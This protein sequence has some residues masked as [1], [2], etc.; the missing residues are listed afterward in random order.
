MHETSETVSLRIF[1]NIPVFGSQNFH[2][3]HI[4]G[5]NYAKGYESLTR[6][7]PLA[8]LS[9]NDYSRFATD[10]QSN[11]DPLFIYLENF[12]TET[13]L[14]LRNRLR[15]REALQ[16]CLGI[17]FYCHKQLKCKQAQKKS[18]PAC[19]FALS[20]RVGCKSVMNYADQKSPA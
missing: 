19:A 12:K 15:I 2:N 6:R 10:S 8:K 1:A 13:H 20:W 18:Y 11:M 5:R 14:R 4:P 17:K 16:S 3:F 9:S 7:I